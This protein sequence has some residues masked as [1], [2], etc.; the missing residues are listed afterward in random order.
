MAVPKR[1]PID[2]LARLHRVAELCPPPHLRRST[3]ALLHAACDGFVDG[4]LARMAAEAAGVPRAA[5]ADGYTDSVDLPALPE[6]SAAAPTL[7]LPV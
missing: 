4:L 3:S 2:E 5:T 6:G 7:L 1:G